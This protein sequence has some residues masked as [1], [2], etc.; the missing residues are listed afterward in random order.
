MGKFANKVVEQ[1]KSWLGK[2]EKDGSFKEVLDVYNR[3]KP[4]PRGYAMKITDEWCAAFVSA[5]AIKLG[6][7]SIIPP[8]CSC[9]KMIDLCKKLGTWV[10]NENRTP[11]AGD[12]I[13]YDWEDN[14]VGDNKGAANH[15]GIVEK[16]A[17]GVV[18]V[19]E[20]NKNSAV[21]RREIKVNGK[22]IRGYAVPKYDAEPKATTT[23]SKDYT[24]VV[25]D[26]KKG[27]YGNGATRV[28]K[29]KAAGYTDAEIIYIQNKVNESYKVKTQPAKKDLNLVAKDVYN[30]KYGNGLARTNKLKAEGYTSAEI[31]EIQKLVNKLCK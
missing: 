12:I 23:T 7:T 22:Y 4:L 19:I 2:N 10:E 5:V 28:K 1:A 17:N 8:E 26:V 16:V 31:K 30:G 14:G 15:V 21:E 3:Y 9:P 13:F 11:K 18:T 6:Y 24:Q 20:G 27:K 29:L 25:N